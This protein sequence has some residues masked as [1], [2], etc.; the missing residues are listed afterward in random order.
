MLVLSLGGFWADTRADEPKKPTLADDARTVLN[1]LVE[2]AADN[3]RLPKRGA[4]G[5]RAPFRRQGDDLTVYYV[6]AAAAAA[7]RLP[8]EQAAPAFAL[9]LGI[10]LDDSTLLRNNLVTRTLW[11]R[12][13]SDAVRAKRLRVLGEPTLHGRHDLALHFSVSAALTAAHGAKAAEAA[14]LLKEM[15]DSNGGSG[16]SFADLS[17]DLAGIAFA[18]RL[19]DKPSLLAEVEKSFT[20]AAY[21]IPPKGLPEGLTAAQ[22]AKRYGSTKDER[23]QRELGEIRKRIEALP[24][25]RKKHK[26]KKSSS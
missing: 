22:F 21:A 4:P 5:A 11:R 7:R 2:A 14:G 6:R 9:A 20:V 17:A 16:F 13:E 18:R 1:K 3:H 24:G 12:V 10:A 26:E 23:F 15:L 25:L 19:I 8:A